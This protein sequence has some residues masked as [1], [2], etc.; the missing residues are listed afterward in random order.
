MRRVLIGWI[1]LLIVCGLSTAAARSVPRRWGLKGLLI[2]V[3]VQLGPAAF[4]GWALAQFDVFLL[5]GGDV[6]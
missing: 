6:Q 4:T 5:G 2:M 1:L 3:P